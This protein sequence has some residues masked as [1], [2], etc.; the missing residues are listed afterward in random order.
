MHR[1]RANFNENDLQLLQMVTI[2]P[3][4]PEISPSGQNNTS[5][6]VAG[7]NFS[8]RNGF[9]FAGFFSSNLKDG[10]TV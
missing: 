8:S 5:F 10:P 6:T 2:D 1:V 9:F 4:N 7:R 3:L